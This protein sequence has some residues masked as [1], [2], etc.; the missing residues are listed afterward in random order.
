MR[1]SGRKLNGGY[2]KSFYQN[3]Y[4][5][6]VVLAVLCHGP[7]LVAY[8]GPTQWASDYELKAAF[9]YN[10]GRFVDWPEGTL[11]DH[12][13]IGINDDGP[14]VSVM[15]KFFAGKRIGQRLIDVREV[16]TRGELRAC[17]ILLI[18]S[19]DGSRIHEV[20]EQLQGANV[21][22]I[23]E[24]E[25][26]AKLGGVVALAQRDNTYKL[27]INPRAAERVQ[28]KISSKL[29]SMATVISESEGH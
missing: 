9:I 22:T 29:M 14:V 10:I 7:M 21:L 19:R 25:Q 2:V 28:L 5:F 20:L 17:N 4:H 26:F 8:E 23:G 18:P 3:A 15:T 13:V 11:G 1:S 16:R 27:A 6:I 12:I 24:G